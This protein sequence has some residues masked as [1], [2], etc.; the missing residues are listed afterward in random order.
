MLIIFMFAVYELMDWPEG[1]KEAAQQTTKLLKSLTAVQFDVLVM[2]DL[3]LLILWLSK[4]LIW[5]T[6]LQMN[7]AKPFLTHC[8]DINSD[9]MDAQGHESHS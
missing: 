5:I 8:C 1:W 9:T 3:I 6:C 2:H 4:Y 7:L